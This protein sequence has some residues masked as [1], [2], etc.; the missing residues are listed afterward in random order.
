MKIPLLTFALVPT[1]LFVSCATSQKTT[2][3]DAARFAKPATGLI[4]GQTIP[5]GSIFSPWRW[6]L[7]TEQGTWKIDANYAGT[8]EGDR[9]ESSISF[10]DGTHLKL[11]TEAVTLACYA[12]SEDPELTAWTNADGTTFV[13]I[14]GS[15]TAT[16]SEGIFA[17][18]NQKLQGWLTRRSTAGL[19]GKP[20]QTS[21][22]V[23]WFASPE[24]IP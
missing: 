2:N 16:H 24:L 17:I 11:P 5:D 20:A 18:K 10:P 3:P 15:I 14:G 23:H 19:P 9:Y 6:T 1:L 12:L 22:Q 8:T 13:S 7:P 21:E 4:V